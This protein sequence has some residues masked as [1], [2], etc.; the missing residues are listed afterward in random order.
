[1]ADSEVPRTLTRA[2]A[3]EAFHRVL[4]TE[5]TMKDINDIVT[6]LEVGYSTTGKPATGTSPAIPAPPSKIYNDY[7]FKLPALDTI[8]SKTESTV[9]ELG[10]GG[11]R[12]TVDR[13]HALTAGASGIVTISTEDTA[14]KC[15]WKEVSCDTPAAVREIFMEAFALSVLQA[16]HRFQRNTCGIHG[17]YRTTNVIRRGPNRKARHPGED[18]RE[19]SAGKRTHAFLIRRGIRDPDEVVPLLAG[20]AAGAAAGAPLAA[21]VGSVTAAE[22]LKLRKAE[23]AAKVATGEEPLVYTF[24]IKMP[25]YPLTLEEVVPKQRWSGKPSWALD[26]TRGILHKIATLLKDL[27]VVYNFSHN[28]LHGKNILFTE[29]KEPVLIDF[30]RVGITIDGTRYKSFGYALDGSAEGAIQNA[31]DSFDLLMYVLSIVNKLP[32]QRPSTLTRLLTPYANLLRATVRS[33][34][35]HIAIDV[36]RSLEATKNAE[37]RARALTGQKLHSLWSMAYTFKMP[38]WSAVV[39]NAFYTNIVTGPT[40][41]ER[42]T[43]TRLLQ[44]RLRPYTCIEGVCRFLGRDVSRRRTKQTRHKRTRHKRT[45]SN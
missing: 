30:G 18:A 34:T 19:E 26:D 38:L 24:V 25:L 35:G 12:R 6:Q 21:E 27:I 33:P 41:S 45:R 36:L 4:G 17:L 29:T 14:N 11:A 23:Y 31:W 13:T 15:I 42:Y 7:I 20:A 40:Q 39:R 28:D 1:M 9:F 43:H 10:K 32:A 22:L 2:Q 16:D 5:F 8:N 37:N 44:D 3:C